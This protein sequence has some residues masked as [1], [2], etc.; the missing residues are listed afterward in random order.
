MPRISIFAV[1]F[2]LSYGG[3]ASVAPLPPA[4][5]GPFNLSVA[6]A[7]IVPAVRQA[8]AAQSNAAP[9]KAIETLEEAWAVAEAADRGLRAQRWNESA[10]EQAV[11]S[12]QA[13]RWPTV[14]VEGSYIGRTAEPSFKVYFEGLPFPSGTFPYDQR[15]NFAAQAKIDLPLYTGG[16]ITHGIAAAEAD[17]A[18]ASLDAEEALMDLKIRVAEAYATVLRAQR[19]VELSESTIRSLESHAHDVEVLLC[20]GQVQQTDLLSV[21]V[22]LANARCDNVQARNRLDNSRAAY[23]RF[24]GRPLSMSVNLV[25]L[26]LELHTSDVESLTSVALHSRPVLARLTNNA[27]ALEHRAECARSKNAPQVCVRGEYD[28]D[29]D[30]YRVPEGIGAA[31]VA[32]TWNLYD[33]GRNRYEAKNL[34]EQAEALRCRRQEMESL[35]ALEVRRAWLDVQETRHRFDAA[36]QAIEQAEENLRVIRKR[37]S[38]STATNTEVLDAETLR[39]LAYRNHDNALYAAILAVFR[40]RHATGEIRGNNTRPQQQG[41]LDSAVSG[42]RPEAHVASASTPQL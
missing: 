15:E 10:A 9:E 36:S 42:N 40:L 23:N 5:Q 37:Y 29:Q 21:Q 17:R 8:G 3:C 18:A 14:G 2:T 6:T 41:G 26:P 11:L 12:A 39:T 27:E 25:E 38:L 22:A 28:Y 1:I 16:R 33:G 19:D 34:L 35:I 30:I 32:V 4:L 24:L 13:E 20:Q 31:G 7:P